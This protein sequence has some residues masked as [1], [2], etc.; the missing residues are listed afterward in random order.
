[1]KYSHNI[2]F[3]FGILVFHI[4]LKYIILSLNL[5][6]ILEDYL[7]ISRNLSLGVFVLY[8]SW[9]DFSQYLNNNKLISI[10][11]SVILLFLSLVIVAED[12]MRTGKEITSYDHF[13]LLVKSFSVAFIEEALFRFYL[14][15]NVYK[16]F[17]N[18]RH[19]FIKS[20]LLTSLVFA[21]AHFNNMFN[22]SYINMSTYVQ[23][24]FA[25]YT[26]ILL[27]SIFIKLKNIL[28]IITL[29]AIINY[30]GSYT[31]YLINE[32]DKI[33][34]NIPEADLMSAI[35]DLL[36]NLILITILGFIIILPI[37]YSLIPKKLWK[38]ND[39]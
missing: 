24:Y 23:V 36:T 5:S 16:L 25:F 12:L 14:F 3:A 32:S 39:W 38:G 26:G 20:L 10:S 19:G 17:E 4:I 8:K 35:P 7:V 34:G 27:Q 31:R 21:L 1:M 18:T 2:L 13:I 37:C 11:I 29:H 6:T 22:P 9:K 15:I 30:L 28:P 33:Q